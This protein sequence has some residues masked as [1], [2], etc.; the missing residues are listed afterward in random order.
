M[1]GTP[2]FILRRPLPADATG[3]AGVHTRGWAQAYGDLL[4]P[5]F[6]DDAA[7]ERRE[8][9]WQRLL[10]EDLVG[11]QVWVAEADAG[12]AG[13]AWRGPSLPQGTEPAARAEQ[14]Y[15]LYILQDWYGTGMGQALLEA[16]LGTEA[17]QLWVADGNDRAQ[18]FYRR[19]GFVEDGVRHVEEDLAGLVE[20][21]MVR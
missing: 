20:L 5:H 7:R 19:N 13:F 17:V 11:P 18:A 14:L 10:G 21:R 2:S 6:Y 12:V 4:P 3:L 9:M 1:P 15:A 16:S 8:E